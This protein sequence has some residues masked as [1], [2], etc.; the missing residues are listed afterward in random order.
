MSV[1][2]PAS[3]T[4][5]QP[6]SRRVH[7]PGIHRLAPPSG[8]AAQYGVSKLQQVP[9][10]SCTRV[11]CRTQRRRPGVAGRG[12]RALAEL[13]QRSRWSR[14]M[15]CA[16]STKPTARQRRET[17]LLRR[18]EEH[19]K[20]GSEIRLGHGMGGL[21]CHG[22]VGRGERRRSLACSTAASAA[23]AQAGGK[24]VATRS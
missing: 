2:W 14:Q 15:G 7:A 13:R 22:G 4:A 24:A 17:E 10:L 12:G 20:N 5:N 21:R 6:S 16:S 9:L 23:R 18:P 3:Q 1:M 19:I 11:Q 8:D